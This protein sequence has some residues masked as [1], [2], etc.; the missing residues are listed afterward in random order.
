[1]FYI[2]GAGK[3]KA[4]KDIFNVSKSN[5]DEDKDKEDDLAC[6]LSRFSFEFDFVSYCNMELL[7]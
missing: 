7:C 6:H 5:N 3:K 2:G 4:V 1:M